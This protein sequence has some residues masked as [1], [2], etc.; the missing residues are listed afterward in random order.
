MPKINLDATTSFSMASLTFAQSEQLVIRHCRDHLNITIDPKEIE[1]AHRLGHHTSDRPRP[2]IVNSHSIKQK[3]PYYLM[4]ASSKE[5]VSVLAKTFLGPSKMLANTYLRL[6][7][8]KIR[9]FLYGLKHYSWARNVMFLMN[10]H[11]LGRKQHSNCP[12]RRK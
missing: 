3:T 1:R 2:V 12:V 9:H 7:K 6:Q 8:A 5:Q 10:H 4:A 11:R